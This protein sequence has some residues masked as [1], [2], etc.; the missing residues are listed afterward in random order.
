MA[1]SREQMLARKLRRSGLSMRD[2]ARRLKV[3]KGSVSLW[4]ADIQLT[5]EQTQKLHEQMVRGSYAGRMLGAR[6]QKEMKLRQIEKSFLQAEQDIQCLEQR[7]LFLA[8][9]A[10]YWGEGDKKSS[11]RFFNSDPRAIGFMMR[12][13]REILHVEEDRFMMYLNINYIHRDRLKEVTEYWSKVTGVPIEKFRKP[14]LVK[15]VNKKVYENFTNHYGTLCIRV[16]K[17]TYLLYQVLGWIRVMSKA[18]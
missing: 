15:T 17:S 14:S 10:L 5:K 8:G 3:S 12:W 6:M 18:G 4:C 1:K 16:A 2:I 9:V 11:V 7:E 13:F